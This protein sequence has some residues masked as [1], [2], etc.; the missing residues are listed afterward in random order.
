M[1][2]IVKQNAQFLQFEWNSSS[3]NDLA[4]TVLI[5]FTSPPPPFFFF[6]LLKLGEKSVH[7]REF[8]KKCVY[9]ISNSCTLSPGSNIMGVDFPRQNVCKVRYTSF[10]EE[11]TTTH[12]HTHHLEVK[13]AVS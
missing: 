3:C 2:L 7:L 6:F 4:Q 10:R 12:T 11:K 9:K 13:Q 1:N 8:K 5:I